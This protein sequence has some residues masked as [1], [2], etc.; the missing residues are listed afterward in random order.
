MLC[1]PSNCLAE[2]LDARVQPASSWVTVRGGAAVEGRALELCLVA[3]KCLEVYVRVRG[4][5][6]DATPTVVTLAAGS[7]GV[8]VVSA[9][10]NI[11]HNKRRHFW[12]RN[13]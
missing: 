8:V 7:R 12:Q 3:K 10:D 4:T 1:D 6:R 11:N 5:M 2:M 9:H 13:A